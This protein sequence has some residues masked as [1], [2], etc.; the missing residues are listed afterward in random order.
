[1]EASEKNPA[2]A[3]GQLATF[4][5]QTTTAKAAWLGGSEYLVWKEA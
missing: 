4:I 3:K 5:V 2:W 1:M